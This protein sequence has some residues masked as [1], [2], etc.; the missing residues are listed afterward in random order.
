MT[1]P[2]RATYRLQLRGGMD[3]AG[4]AG[5]VPYLARLGISH[6]YLSPPF[7]AAPGSTHGYDVV[8]PNRLDPDA[9][10][11]GGIR[12]AAP[13][14]GRA[15]SR[16][17]PGHRAQPHGHRA[18]PTPGGGTCC[19]TAG[20]AA[21][22][23]TSPSTSPPTRAASWSC[24]CSAARWRRCWNAASCGWS[25]RTA[26]NSSPT[27]TSGS[28]WLRAERPHA[29]CARRWTPSTIGSSAGAKV[30]PRRNYRRFF[31]IDQ[32]AGA[33][34]EDERGVRGQPP[35]DPRSCRARS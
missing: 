26:R 35:A 13:R 9:R 28:R 8:D 19:A 34:V 23:A 1:A 6:L 24:R 21:T 30:P 22:P 5:I 31:N 27:S 25:A 29:T 15:R 32:L 2:P 20:T 18:Q 11:R 12:A 14:T 16:A 4:A 3:F 17:D 33:R 10:R 7:A